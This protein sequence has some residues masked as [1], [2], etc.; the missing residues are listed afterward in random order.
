VIETEFE[1]RGTLTKDSEPWKPVSTSPTPDVR[2]IKFIIAV[3]LT[4]ASRREFES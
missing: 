3:D 1:A 4:L 2:G